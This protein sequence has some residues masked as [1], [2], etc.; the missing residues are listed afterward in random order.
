MDLLK[1]IS[2]IDQ[3]KAFNDKKFKD[4]RLLI[5]LAAL[6]NPKVVNWD[7]VTDGSTAEDM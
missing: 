6:V 1:W 2:E 3:V 4:G 7:L 5:K